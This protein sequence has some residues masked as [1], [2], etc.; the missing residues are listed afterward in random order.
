MV[1]P[2]SLVGSF[3]YTERG[4]TINTTATLSG[5]GEFAPPERA[6]VLRGTTYLCRISPPAQWNV[7]S[8]P[9]ERCFCCES[10]IFMAVYLF[11]YRGMR[12]TYS[13]S[14]AADFFAASSTLAGPPP[15]L[16]AAFN[17]D[18]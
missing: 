10:G 5:A 1:W 15:Y 8:R 12:F 9:V 18:Y 16:R 3:R 4:R 6:T 2:T 11:W 13:S 14:P 17:T 7:S